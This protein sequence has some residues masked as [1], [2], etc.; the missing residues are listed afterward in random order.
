M[1][2]RHIF[3]FTRA[4]GYVGQRLGKSAGGCRLP[5]VSLLAPAMLLSSK[6]PRRRPTG[7]AG[8]GG[9]DLLA[10]QSRAA[11]LNQAA[12][13]RR[14]PLNPRG[15]SDSCDDELGVTSPLRSRSVVAGVVT[16]SRGRRCPSCNLAPQAI[17]ER[18]ERIGELSRGFRR[19]QRHFEALCAGGWIPLNPWMHRSPG[20]VGGRKSANKLRADLQ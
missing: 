19:R 14:P 13:A 11:F 10:A 15:S 20:I 17:R 7:E 2:I 1:R 8:V 18:R 16:P 9:P 3:E 4:D 5:D 12:D 6:Q